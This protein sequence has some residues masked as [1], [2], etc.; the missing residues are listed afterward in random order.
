MQEE[1][2]AQFKN[3][4]FTRGIK[5][6]SIDDL[7]REM[8][9]S[10]KTIYQH[11]EDKEDLVR[12]LLKKHLEEHKLIIEK[13]HEESE[14][15]IQELLLIMQCSTHMLTQVNPVVFEDLKHYYRKAWNHFEEFKKEYVLGRIKKT[16]EKGQKQKLIRKNI[17]LDLM[18]H[19]RLKEIEFLMD[20]QFIRSFNMSIQ[21]MQKNITEYFIL[22]VGTPEGIKK[23]YEYL[24]NPQKIKF[25]YNC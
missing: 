18:A 15:V 14:D 7:A 25:N 24:E 6:V 22:G 21:E 17:P 12:K 4:V 19:F 13:I 8:K 1:I 3:L 20:Y 23:M 2:L 5:A 16:L 9:I 11:F 10:K